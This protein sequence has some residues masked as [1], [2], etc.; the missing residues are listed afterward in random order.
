MF[1]TKLVSKFCPN[2][3]EKIKLEKEKNADELIND[4]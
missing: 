4:I 1:D 3:G 2:C